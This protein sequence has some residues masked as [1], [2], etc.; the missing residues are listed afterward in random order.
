MIHRRPLA[1]KA[2]VRCQ[3]SPGGMCDGQSGMR[4][5]FLPLFL[6]YPFSI[7]PSKLHA[8]STHCFCRKDKWAKHS[9]LLQ[10]Q[11]SV[12]HRGALNSTALLFSTCHCKIPTLLLFKEWPCLEL[13]TLRT[14]L[15]NC[16]NARSRGLTFR[17]RASC[18]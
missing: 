14:G 5:A 2:W 12:V 10:K 9:S 8:S 15:L 16:L 3:A 4:K 17:H 13:N 18:I 6:F 11:Y 7:I 1:A